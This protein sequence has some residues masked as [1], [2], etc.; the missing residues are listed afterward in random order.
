[1]RTLA[2]ILSILVC[3]KSYAFFEGEKYCIPSQAKDQSC[4]EGDLIVVPA[5]LFAMKF[6]DFE[7]QVVVIPS[8]NASKMD[9]QVI[10]YFI[11]RERSQRE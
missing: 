11:G 5:P 3:S 10:C 2:F 9:G 6:C 8:G 4:K 7:K 1:M